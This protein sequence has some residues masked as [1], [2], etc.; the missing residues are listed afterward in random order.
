MTKYNHKFPVIKFYL[1]KLWLRH[2]LR[3]LCFAGSE[4]V[5][6][7]WISSV[8]RHSL[9]KQQVCSSCDWLLFLFTIITCDDEVM[10]VSG[11]FRSATLD[12]A[13]L[14]PNSQICVALMVSAQIYVAQKQMSY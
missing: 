9:Y 7:R 2:S 3:V 12:C 4:N 6:F 13:I 8:D 10:T 11:H 14:T 5:L 1:F